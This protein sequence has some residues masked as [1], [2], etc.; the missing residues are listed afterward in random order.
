MALYIGK[1]RFK[2]GQEKFVMTDGTSGYVY[3][4]L[5]ELAAQVACATLS[6]VLARSDE[7]SA[8]N[9]VADESVE[10]WTD[11]E[12]GRVEPSFWS[13]ASSDRTFLTGCRSQEN[14]AAAWKRAEE[15]SSATP[16]ARLGT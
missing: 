10:V 4:A 14:W 2:D 7:L 11:I 15:A 6:T 9:L 12:L 1:V 16:Y 13:T 8:L 3:P 5:F